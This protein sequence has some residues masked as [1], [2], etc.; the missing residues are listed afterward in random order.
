MPRPLLHMSTRIVLLGLCY[1]LVG[2]ASLPSVWP[3]SRRDQAAG[4]ISGPG[5]LS[6]SD[7]SAE[8]PL[9]KSLPGDFVVAAVEKVGPS[10]VR[11]DTLQARDHFSF[12]IFPGDGP[13]DDNPPEGQGSG[14]ITRSDGIVLTNHHVVEGAERVTVTLRSGR[15]YTGQV[16]G[17]DVV[18]DL[19]IVKIDG[20]ENLPVARLGNS[21]EVRPGEW[22]IA[23]GNPLGLNNSVS[24]GIVSAT[25]RTTGVPGGSRVSYIQTDA[26]INPGNSGG[27]L[28]NDHAQVIGI[29]TFI[30]TSPG[31]GISFA[32][33]INKAREIGEQIITHGRASHP[34]IG[35]SLRRIT[36]ELAAEINQAEAGCAYPETDGVAVVDVLPDHPAAQAG[37]QPCDVIRTVAGVEVRTPAQVQVQVDRGRVGEPLKLDIERQGLPRT[38]MVVPSELDLELF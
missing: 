2:C 32:I 13:L 33:P 3:P 26:A 17:S 15:S 7:G 21:D 29:N 11:I 5:K 9:L 38:L 28:I 8:R 31:G 34:F 18:T 12:H 1:V 10:V 14:F 23:I 25:D 22:A 24:L 37:L 16:L 27:P 4:P 30:R 6:S 20:A 19:G 36:Q 35:V